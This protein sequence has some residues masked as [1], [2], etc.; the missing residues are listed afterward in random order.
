MPSESRLQQNYQY[1]GDTEKQPPTP[2]VFM[3]K[4]GKHKI[5]MEIQSMRVLLFQK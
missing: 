5:E 2:K 4:Y 1:Q 3:H